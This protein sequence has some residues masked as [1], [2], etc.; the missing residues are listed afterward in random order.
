MKKRWLAFWIATALAAGTV[1]IAFGFSFGFLVVIPTAAV[2]LIAFFHFRSIGYSVENRRLLIRSGVLFGKR[3]VIEL[4]SVLWTTEV[5]IG[6]AT[7]FSVLHTAGGK[8]VVFL[9]REFL[10]IST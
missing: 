10:T 2:W 5:K 7:L 8:A 9:P 1:V 6:S 3:R 4:S